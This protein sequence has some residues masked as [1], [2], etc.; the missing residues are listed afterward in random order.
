[1]VGRL[2]KALMLK[3]L[4]N[5]KYSHT[6]DAGYANEGNTPLGSLVIAIGMKAILTELN[7]K[8]NYPDPISLTTSFIAAPSREETVE[9]HIYILKLGRNFAFAQANI[10]RGSAGSIVILATVLGTCGNLD[11]T[12]RHPILDTVQRQNRRYRPFE[13]FS[14]AS[15]LPPEDCTSLY[16]RMERRALANYQNHISYRVDPRNMDANIKQLERDVDLGRIDVGNSLDVDLGSVWV[17]EADG[18]DADVYS[19]TMWTD[20]PPSWQGIVSNKYFNGGGAF[21]SWSTISETIHF[22]RRVPRNNGPWL[23]SQQIATWTN[24]DILEFEVGI[25][26]GKNGEDLIAIARQVALVRQIPSKL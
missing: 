13:G 10:V 22:L 3:S 6:F 19:V 2:D 9:I 12:H 18:R 14:S 8:G 26:G 5:G 23:K 24:R 11:T 7:L 20:S 21:D 16:D 4:G 15:N 17:G 1:M 25:Y